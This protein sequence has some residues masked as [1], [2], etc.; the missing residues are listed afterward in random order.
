[1]W[2]VGRFYDGSNELSDEEVRFANI[3]RERGRNDLAE[4]VMKVRKVQRFYFAFGPSGEAYGD[5][6]T[7]MDLFA[8]LQDAFDF[9]DE[10]WRNGRQRSS[11]QIK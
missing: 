9:G 6:K 10:E 3:F 2:P 11:M 4:C 7:F 1:M 5:R 8:G